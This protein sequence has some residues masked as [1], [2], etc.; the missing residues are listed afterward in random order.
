MVFDIPTTPVMRKCWL[1]YAG[2]RWRDFKSKLSV[3]YIYG[4]K[5]NKNPCDKYSY[6]DQ[7][8]WA[9]FV[10]I[11]QDPKSKVIRCM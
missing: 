10:A 8:T 11:C 2:A 5:Q 9:K 3:R 7:V 6:L 1:S 4:D